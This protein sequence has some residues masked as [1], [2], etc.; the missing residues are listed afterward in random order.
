MFLVQ[1][2]LFKNTIFRLNNVTSAI[3]VTLKYLSMIIPSYRPS[4]AGKCASAVNI[5]NT[6]H[7]RLHFAV[8]PTTNHPQLVIMS[9]THTWESIAQQIFKRRNIFILYQ[10]SISISASKSNAFSTELCSAT[11]NRKKYW[12]PK[13]QP[14]IGL[15]R[16]GQGKNIDL[17]QAKFIF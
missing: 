5:L 17:S 14:L 16:T 7:L 1:F 3:N 8:K 2:S 11:C 6:T 10:E 9:R 15:I 4:F 13:L 12:V